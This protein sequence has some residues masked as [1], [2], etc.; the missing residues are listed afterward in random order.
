[1]GEVDLISRITP[2]QRP[3]GYLKQ[4][5]W[6]ATDHHVRALANDGLP[7]LIR[8]RLEKSRRKHYKWQATLGEIN[9]LPIT[10]FSA[11]IERQVR[12]MRA[13]A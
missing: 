6:P 12:Q 8:E 1:M 13:T 10:S 9:R 2:S 4:I 5:L 11:A 7:D 3:E